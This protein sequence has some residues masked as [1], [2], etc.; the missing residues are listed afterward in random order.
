MCRYVRRLKLLVAP[1][2]MARI[3]RRKSLGCFT[4]F[5]PPILTW[6][7]LKLEV[8]DVTLANT[9][10]REIGAGAWVGYRSHHALLL[11]RLTGRRHV[12][13]MHPKR[14]GEW[15][16]AGS[17]V[18]PQGV[19]HTCGFAPAP[20]MA[21]TDTG[22]LLRLFSSSRRLATSTQPAAAQGISINISTNMSWLTMQADGWPANRGDPLLRSPTMRCLCSLIAGVRPSARFQGHSSGRSPAAGIFLA[23]DLED[24]P[25]DGYCSL[26]MQAQ[27]AHAGFAPAVFPDVA[28]QRPVLRRSTLFKVFN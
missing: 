17:H 11:G 27:E 4:P 16:D 5:R 12:S 18:K 22:T 8:Q 26:I 3:I 15:R 2:F 1:S 13:N 24:S 28:Q 6:G 20:A 9:C 14:P 7:F 21:R 19:L 10:R 23:C 25:I